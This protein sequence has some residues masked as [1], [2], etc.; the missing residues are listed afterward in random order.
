MICLAP[1]CPRVITG[2]GFTSS[3]IKPREPAYAR[4][5]ITT[6][7]SQP[8]PSLIT[9]SLRDNNLRAAALS[10]TNVLQL[11]PSLVSLDLANNGL[12]GKI[13]FESFATLP[14]L[15]TLDL[16]SNGLDDDFFAAT[17]NGVDPPSPAHAFPSLTTLNIAKN[18][19]D[20]LN[21]L[22]TCLGIGV[23]RKAEYAGIVSVSLRRYITAAQVEQADATSATDLPELTID[24][25]DNF[26]RKELDR[27]KKKRRPERQDP[28][29]QPSEVSRSQESPSEKN[30]VELEALFRDVSRFLDAIAGNINTPDVVNEGEMAEIRDVVA[31]LRAYVASLDAK[32]QEE[33]KGTTSRSD[34]EVQPQGQRKAQEKE[35][36]WG[37]L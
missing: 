17:L 33:E 31:P 32:K 11:P 5:A 36:V 13:P 10:V 16:S 35:Y 22:E 24:I 28:T 21:H 27:R 6:D 2:S 12:S 3:P 20:D 1:L 34:R 19:I 18:A 23:H 25:R 37:P 30:K 8:L 26:L 29:P 4:T 14:S 9:L 7:F 15:K